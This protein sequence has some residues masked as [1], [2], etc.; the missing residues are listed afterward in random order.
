MHPC[1]TLYFITC[2]IF[3]VSGCK[4][5]VGS[6]ATGNAA[7]DLYAEHV[8]TTEWLSPENEKNA[9]ELPPGFEI[10]L[11][12]SEP[13]ITKPINMEFDDRG[14]LWV[15]Q[16]SEY[17]IEAGMGDGHDR[18]TILEDKNGDGTADS[19]TNFADD[20]NIP[21][22][23]MPVSDGAI[24]YSIPNL[25]YFKDLNQ[26]GVADERKRLLGPFG[27][28][29]THGMVNNII[30]GF[31]GD[32]H[33]CHGF[34][35]TSTVAGT[36][37]D[38]ITMVSGN[39][40]RV[41][42][43]GRHVTQT[44][45]GRVNPFGQDYDERGFLY[46][47]DCHTKPIAQLIPK[48]DY[49]HFGKKAADGIGFAPEMMHYDLGSTAL[50][51]LVYYTGEQFP[52]K[53]RQS[54][55]TGD[56]VTCRI[57]RN[58][59]SFDGSSPKAKKETPFLVSSD[60]WFRPVDIKLGPDGSLYIADFYNRIIGH[61]E[62]ALNHEGRDRKS[63]RIWK[64]TYK[65]NEH[66]QNTAPVDWSK[67]SL[68]ELLAG[69]TNTQLNTRLKIADRIVD[70]KGTEAIEPIKTNMQAN[71]GNMIA[72]VHSL[73][74]L[75]RLNALDES[76]IAEA[77]ES[78]S[79]VVQVHALRIMKEKERLTE[80]DKSKVLMK[81]SNPD[82]F[83]RRVAT[84]VLAKFPMPDALQ[85][86]L[87]LCD[88][89]D[90]ADTHLR[91]S[92]LLAIRENLKND[93]VMWYVPNHN[94][95]DKELKLLS[96]VMLDVPT[97]AAA[98]FVINYLLNHE[99]EHD[100]LVS[101]LKYVARFTPSYKLESIVD[102]IQQKFPD[103]LDEQLALFNNLKIGIA[104]SGSKASPNLRDW[105]R[106]LSHHFLN[107]I[108]E[109]KDILKSKPVD[110]LVAYTDPWMVSEQFLTH[111]S[112]PFRI[113]FS[114]RKGFKQKGILYSVPFK[115]P[116]KLNM[117]IFDNDIHNRTSKTGVSQ[118][119]VRIKLLEN[120]KVIAEYRAEE[121]VKMPLHNLIKS[122][123]FDLANFSGKMGYI[124][125]V[126]SS[127]TGSVGFGKFEPAI[128][129]ISKETPFKRAEKRIQAINNAE[130]FGLIE[131]EPQ[132]KKILNSPWQ[133]ISVRSAAASALLNLDS[134]NNF[135]QI[136]ALFNDPVALQDL[137][138]QLVE[139]LS[140]YQ[141]Q[142]VFKALRSGF[143]GASRDLQ[144]VIA[145][146]LAST[147]DGIDYLLNAFKNEDLP[148]EVATENLIKERVDNNASKIQ[149]AIFDEYYTAGAST[150]EKRQ[151]LIDAR[152][153]GFNS[154]GSSEKGKEVFKQNCSS[155]HQI[156]KEGGMIGP[157]LDGIGNWGSLALT[158]K[159]L[160]PNRNITE[161]FRTY[162]ITLKNG[163]QFMGLYRRTVGEVMIFADLT[164][165][166]FS[167]SKNEIQTNL[168]S[169][170]TLMPD[171]FRNTIPE[172]E[173]Y[174]LMRFLV[175]VK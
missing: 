24:A 162:N 130:E 86:L 44:T 88:T 158:Q 100:K 101:Y 10:T 155:C 108:S 22:G 83:V 60:P 154:N 139:I 12:A 46:S 128:I 34:S 102:L 70:T 6:S 105:G 141:S 79:G 118:N 94:W 129:T 164:G 5:P 45:F 110:Q 163:K 21:I 41:D 4:K 119:V 19:F 82:P 147:E 133:D 59:I 104:Q 165:A 9:F 23:I 151:V 148:L 168:P 17:P 167:I 149:K 111:I 62:V 30:R 58:T 65:G 152:L 71:K 137:R 153:S 42:K 54:F 120:N 39:T 7:K 52:E 85:P 172:Q 150:K 13:N 57:D 144:L 64:V 40:F 25:I 124:E 80:D 134:K 3:I 16:S 27:H 91:Y 99:V 90:S 113:I 2:F 126:D 36:D 159:I 142:E 125:A 166:E 32:F 84:E 146:A 109:E 156:N 170:Y 112:P 43:N 117:N 103:D 77:L 1:R 122:T 157:Q 11:F 107:D 95:T 161:A 67:A 115:I 136:L 173:F 140:L 26:D 69:L 68:N 66:H 73:W 56:V 97:S 47:V 37:G 33:I 116:E 132:L 174:D 74:I 106:D 138:K 78:T 14:R 143:S 48:G 81:L 55:F 50:A 63:G 76:I 61:Y 93:A 51:G 160:D 29:D 114:E 171:N 20:L 53:Y 75:H 98:S 131:L 49:P 92:S 87:T 38:S 169:K 135:Q 123:T 127:E 72:Y 31:D 89:T 28:Q 121:K 15:T 175:N 35:N 96:E 145:A 18:I 8:R